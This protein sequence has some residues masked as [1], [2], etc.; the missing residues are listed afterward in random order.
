MADSRV[1][2]PLSRAGDRLGAD[3]VLVRPVLAV[4]HLVAEIEGHELC[5]V[6]ERAVLRERRLQEMVVVGPLEQRRSRG[7]GEPAE[8]APNDDPIDLHAA[9]VDRHAVAGPRRFGDVADAIHGEHT[10]T[11]SRAADAPPGEGGLRIDDLTKRYGTLVAVDGLTLTVPRGAMIGFLGPNGAG[12]T[13]TMRF[14]VGMVRPDRGS[15][16]WD[17]VPIDDAFRNRIGYM[18]QERGLYARMKVREQIM[19][20]GRLAG[21]T[22]PDAATRVDHWLDR[23]GLADR[24]DSLLEDLSGG[25]QQRVQLAVSLVHDPRLL[26]LDE[27]FAG[28]DPVAAETM[29][30]IVAERAAEG[31]SVLFSSHQLDLVEGLCET[32]AIVADG[33]LVAAGEIADLRAAS[34]T[35][36]LRVRW[37]SP[38]RDW[39]PSVGVLR[40]FD[41]RRAHVELDRDAD[42]GAAIADA[43]RGGAVTEIAVEPPGLDDVFAELVGGAA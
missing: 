22:K 40:H 31:T 9:T 3:V 32:V 23:L 29:R 13:T 36:V 39:T 33:R 43:L 18:P 7:I 21:L 2:E 1:V 26:V 5:V 35:R 30:E 24:A 10:V 16:T 25:N 15:I 6:G 42:V 12:K 4:A 37:D 41:G 28:L 34:A 19:Y 17:G 27:P 8:L 38:V 11:V 20:F 14:I